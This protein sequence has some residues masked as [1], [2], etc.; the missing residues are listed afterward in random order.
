M[1][2]I[3]VALSLLAIIGVLCGVTLS[4][5][6]RAV[7]DLLDDIDAIQQTFPA[8]EKETLRQ[9]R[10]LVEDFRTKT[11]FFPLF[12]HH[13]DLSKIEETAVML[14][15]MLETGE[16]EHFQ[17]ELARCRNMLEKL[18]ELEIPTL[19]NIF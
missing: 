17:A 1:K 6:R 10:Q 3:T 5:Q 13:S 11:R 15:V 16:E 4:A 18:A 19:E 12:M 9:T 2:R 7:D 14:P 8:D